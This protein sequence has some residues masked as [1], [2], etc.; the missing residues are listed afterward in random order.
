[1][2]SRVVPE[3]N[4]GHWLYVSQLDVCFDD[5]KPFR[6][7]A[8][9][10]PSYVWQ[11]N[12]VWV[13]YGE[14]CFNIALYYAVRR[15]GQLVPAVSRQCQSSF[16]KSRLRRFLGMSGEGLSRQERICYGH[17][18][19]LIWFAQPSDRGVLRRNVIVGRS[20]EFSA[21]VTCVDASVFRRDPHSPK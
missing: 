14:Y 12:W 1:M 15:V 9:Q 20:D 18:K 13:L 11:D 19:Y 2:Y 4:A 17:I 10:S 7:C 6:A 21:N 5:V 8:F 16:L 3:Q